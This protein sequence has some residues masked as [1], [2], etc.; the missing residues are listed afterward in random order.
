M[1]SQTAYN[2]LAFASRQSI[3]LKVARYFAKEKK[4]STGAEDTT[5][6]SII[7]QHYEKADEWLQAAEYWKVR[8]AE[9]H[10]MSS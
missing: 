1:P 9:S 3:H 5:F 7:A 6:Y 2:T 4:T 10:I 8:S